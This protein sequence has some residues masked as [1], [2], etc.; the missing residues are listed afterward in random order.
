[1]TALRV[2]DSGSESGHGGEVFSCVYSADGAFVLS[3]GWDGCLRLWLSENIQ[4]ISSL[5]AS[6]R[7]LSCCAFAPDGSA[8]LSA[9]MDG[10]LSWWDAMTHQM[11]QT[12]I[13]HIRPI[14]ALQ[15]SPDGRFLATASWDRKL[16][17]RR[18]G[19]ER[20]GRALVGHSDIVAGCRWS[21]DGE[22]LLSWSHDGTLR[23]WNADGAREVARFEGHAE[24]ITA[25]CLSKNGQWAISGG[26]DGSV[27]LWD[28]RQRVEVRSVQLKD[29]VR[30]CWCLPDDASVLTV[31]ADGWIV[32]WSLPDFEVQAEL[33]SGIRAMCGDLSPSGSE[34]VLGSEKGSLHFVVIEGIEATPLA[35]T[36]TRLFKPRTGVITRFLGKQQIE[37]SYQYSC[38]ACGHTEETSRLPRETIP[39]L[40]CKRLLQVCP[41]ARELQPQ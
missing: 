11:K 34:V 15:F 5:E 22:Q 18:V 24:R 26:R 7:P 16:M 12:F 38:P 21:L 33:S 31:C 1:M 9:A 32:V 29:E 35:V 40:S 30:G 20:E 17:L 37:Q 28:L 23:L 14:S 27:K 4:P 39:C 19:D 41:E 2:R 3:G 25:A 8:W 13:A 6:N 36:P 10:T